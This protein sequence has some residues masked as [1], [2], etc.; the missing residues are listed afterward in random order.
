M[1]A[2][3]VYVLNCPALRRRALPNRWGQEMLL[4]AAML[5]REGCGGGQTPVVGLDPE[6]SF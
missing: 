4:T 2:T 6:D 1:T 5:T 3:T